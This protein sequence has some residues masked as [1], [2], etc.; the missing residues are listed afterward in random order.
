MLLG[1]LMVFLVLSDQPAAGLQEQANVQ[2]QIQLGRRAELPRGGLATIPVLVIVDSPEAYA[3]AVTKW[4][5]ESRFPVLI[6]AGTAWSAH[7]TGRHTGPGR[8]T[9]ADASHR[10]AGARE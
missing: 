7:A 2:A 3:H 6:D 8:R 9:G 10:L 4:T 5:P 1:C